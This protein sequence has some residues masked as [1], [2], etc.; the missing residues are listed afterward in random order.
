M[1]IFSQA[2]P[3]LVFPLTIW[4]NAKLSKPV[5]YPD[6]G[7]VSANLQKHCFNVLNKFT[8]NHKNFAQTQAK[9]GP[10]FA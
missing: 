9:F 2:G 3:P 4:A 5:L 8:Q 7:N 6:T 1:Q 10:N